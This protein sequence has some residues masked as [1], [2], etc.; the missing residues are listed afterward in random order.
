MWYGK[1]LLLPQILGELPDV[2]KTLDD[3]NVKNAGQHDINFEASSIHT[4]TFFSAPKNWLMP[5]EYS[6]TD[7]N[8]KVL[9]VKTHS[10]VKLTLGPK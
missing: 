2:L 9:T 7:T 4:V 8:S 1:G 3:E 10:S 6:R 5:S